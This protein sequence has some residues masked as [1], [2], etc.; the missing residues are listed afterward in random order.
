L[1]EGI[2]AYCMLDDMSEALPLLREMG[3]GN[4]LTPIEERIR[5]ASGLVAN[6]PNLFDGARELVNLF[7]GGVEILSADVALAPAIPPNDWVESN[8]PSHKDSEVGRIEVSRELLAALDFCDI[9]CLKISY[10][11]AEPCIRELLTI[12]EKI[13]KCLENL[14]T[15]SHS[16]GVFIREAV[17]ERLMRLVHRELARFR[18][19]VV[20][21]TLANNNSH[22]CKLE[23]VGEVVIEARK[24]SSV[25]QAV[26][27]SSMPDPELRVAVRAGKSVIWVK[28]DGKLQ[29]EFFSD[30]LF[31]DR[32]ENARL[33][34]AIRTMEGCHLVL[35]H[36]DSRRRLK[37]GFRRRR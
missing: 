23:R 15:K 6:V 28:A 4:V 20:K 27:K 25:N 19:V 30:D 18:R 35:F 14:A 8:S 16:K 36:R 13:D 1:S 22:P 11:S 24:P 5:Q 3:M 2:P 12:Q 34:E 37:S 10:P 33:E 31:P 7:T 32:P 21:V 29:T 26:L 9:S 17:C